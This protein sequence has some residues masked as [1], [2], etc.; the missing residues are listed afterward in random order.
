MGYSNI[1]VDGRQ[2]VRASIPP[3]GNYPDK[4][5]TYPSTFEDIRAYLKMKNFFLEITLIL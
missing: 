2:G 1:G 3:L 4:S 5:G